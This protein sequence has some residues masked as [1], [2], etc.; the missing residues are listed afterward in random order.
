MGSPFLKASRLASLDSP[1]GLKVDHPLQPHLCAL[2]G[3]PQAPGPGQY[4]ACCCSHTPPLSLFPAQVRECNAP[5]CPGRSPPGAQTQGR[6]CPCSPTGP[7]ST[8]QSESQPLAHPCAP[9]RGVGFGV[10][11]LWR[12]HACEREQLLANVPQAAPCSL[13]SRWGAG[14]WECRGVQRPQGKGWVGIGPLTP[15][16]P[17]PLTLAGVRREQHFLTVFPPLRNTEHL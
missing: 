9:G 7:A 5:A 16:A 11:V 13:C 10:R 12:S 4:H 6:P 2:I 3:G 14:R 15:G 1:L 17:Q 8:S